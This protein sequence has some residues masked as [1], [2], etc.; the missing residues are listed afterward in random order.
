MP[1]KTNDSGYRLPLIISLLVVLILAIAVG[2][3]VYG[4]SLQSQHFIIVTA[5]GTAT[6]SPSTA[7]IY[8]TINATGSTAV[9]ANE[10][11]ST[12]V[13]EFNTTILPFLNGNVSEIQT[14]S[15]QVYQPL[16]CTYTNFTYQC[17]KLDYYAATESLLV[18]LPDVKSIS[19]ATAQMLAIPHLQLQ[20]VQAVLS[21]SQKT[22][23]NQ[24]AL[25]LALANAT[26]QATTLAGGKSITIVNIS[27]QSGY[28]YYPMPLGV[29]S[30][31][32]GKAV[33]GT[34]FY[35]GITSE[36]KSVYVVFSTN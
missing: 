27:V 2:T 23:L 24:K 28:L 19:S 20:S 15:Y 5:T 30:G 26:A 1:A 13:G 32:S 34:A 35:G 4:K 9:L 31:S 29:V 36:E 22:A 21:D 18:T 16:N 8:T 33:N 11:L 3:M 6:A 7:E 25:S 12:S 17:K 14:Q 10:N